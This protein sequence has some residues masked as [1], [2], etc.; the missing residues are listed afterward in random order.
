MLFVKEDG[1][2]STYVVFENPDF[3]S[4]LQIT[5]NR[6]VYMLPKYVCVLLNQILNTFSDC[7]ESSTLE[8][9]TQ[10]LTLREAKGE[11]K[12]EE[13][14]YLQKEEMVVERQ[15]RE[16]LRGNLKGGAGCPP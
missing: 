8:E 6:N 9:G 12:T 3:I 16:E 2:E 1:F 4:E 11:K 10:R 15:Q 13:E 7:A 5:Q 14:A